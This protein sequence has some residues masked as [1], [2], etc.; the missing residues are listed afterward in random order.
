MYWYF[1]KTVGTRTQ[2]IDWP[3]EVSTLISIGMT[4][5]GS[6][7]LLWRFLIEGNNVFANSFLD[8]II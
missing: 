4:I 1:S 3:L 8:M 5:E 6:C 2:H 7:E